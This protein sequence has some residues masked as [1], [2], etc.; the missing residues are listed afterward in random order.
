MKP[1]L[2]L[3]LV[4]DHQLFAEAIQ[5]VLQRLANEVVVRKVTSCEEALDSL[6]VARDFDLVL[7]DLGLPGLRNEAA[8]DAIRARANGAPIVLVTADD[9]ASVAHALLR[10]GARGYVPKSSSSEL[11]LTALRLV[12]SGGTYLPPSVLDDT[13]H[14]APSIILTDR[15]RDVLVGIAA[16][17]SNRSIADELG[18]AEAT[19]R[20]HVSGLFRALGVENRTQAA[21]SPIASELRRGR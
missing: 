11:M 17:K 14:T 21:T 19:V 12:L 5:L 1:R 9:N 4:D 6:S 20:V 18:I 10:R 2:R 15:Q 8:Y 3:L 13:R 7:L 16:G